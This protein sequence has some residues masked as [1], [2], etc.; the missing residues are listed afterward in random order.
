MV[1]FKPWLIDASPSGKVAL[2]TARLPLC[3]VPYSCH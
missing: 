3:P 1:R 2:R